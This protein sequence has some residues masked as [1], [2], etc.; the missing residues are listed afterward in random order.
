MSWLEHLSRWWMCIYVSRHGSHVGQSVWC[1]LEKYVCVKEQNYG[2]QLV[3]RCTRCLYRKLLKKKTHNRLKT[4]KTAFYLPWRPNICKKSTPV[5]MRRENSSS[6][7]T[8][9]SITKRIVTKRTERNEFLHRL[10]A[11]QIL[12]SPC[13]W[14]LCIAVCMRVS[15]CTC[16]SILSVCV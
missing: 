4:S 6:S 8:F 3:S 5:G 1:M 9:D 7:P 2:S 13:A 15:T 16:K 11:P 10:H 12:S 14:C